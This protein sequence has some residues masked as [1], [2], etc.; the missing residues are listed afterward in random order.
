MNRRNHT[1]AW[2][3]TLLVSALILCTVAFAN[4]GPIMYADYSFDRYDRVLTKA[5]ER[6]KKIY[7]A[8]YIMPSGGSLGFDRKHRNHLTLVRR[9]MEDELPARLAVAKTMQKAFDLILAYPT[10]GDF[11]AYQFITDINYS[12]ITDFSEMDFVVPGPG[13]RDGLRKCLEQQCNHCGCSSS[14][15]TQEALPAFGDR[16]GSTR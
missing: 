12:A 10:I 4:G 8:A 13:A 1:T 3:L 15:V 14:L 9:M 5:M 6:G 2:A 16:C 7:S 11:L